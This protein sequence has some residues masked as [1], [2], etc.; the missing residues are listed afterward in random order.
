MRAI[1][2]A[3]VVL[4]MTW[5]AQSA[6]ERVAQ[7]WAPYRL[8][9]AQRQ[10]FRSIRAPSGV[11]CCDIS[12]GHPTEME[13]RLDGVYI[14][15]PVHLEL[16]R[17]WVKVPDEAVVKGIANPVGIA[18]VWYVIQGPDTVYIRCFVPEAET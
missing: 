1:L 18:T 2:L 4:V 11:P 5:P 15:D 8:N 10:W 17:Q 9:E 7:E 13:R 12:D 3:F 6:W 14:P 16:P